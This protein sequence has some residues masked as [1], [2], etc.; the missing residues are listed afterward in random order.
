[1]SNYSSFSV[2][3]QGYSHIVKQ[4]PCEDNSLHFDGEG[5]HIGAVADGHGD[6]K[7]FRSSIGSSLAVKLAEKELLSLAKSRKTENRPGIDC[8]DENLMVKDVF[9]PVGRQI[10]KNIIGKWSDEVFKNYQDAPVSDEEIETAGIN[11]ISIY[12]IEDIRHIYGTTLVAFLLTDEYLLVLHQGDGRCVIVHQDGSIDQPVPWDIRCVGRET[13]SLCDVDAVNSF[14]YYVNDQKD[15]PIIACF[16]ASDG[17]ED[18]FD[19]QEEVNSFFGFLTAKCVELGSDGITDYLEKILP[20]YSKL[21]SRDDISI[22]GV[23]DKVAAQPYAE[24]YLL[25]SELHT[26]EA[27]ARIAKNK[28][29]SM[30]RKMGYLSNEFDKAKACYKATIEACE[31]ATWDRETITKRLRSR[32]MFKTKNKT[33]CKAEKAF[34][35]AKKEYDA[36]RERYNTFIQKLEEANDKIEETKESLALLEIQ[37]MSREDVAIVKNSTDERSN[38]M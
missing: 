17:V 38:F 9:D 34:L 10:I 18:S 16:V 4:T 36:Y 7:C 27:E 24:K 31:D 6:K 30:F 32:R 29:D 35:S 5:I 1:M 21:G 37:K 20:E 13:T 28:L 15:E 3:V 11:N 33:D 25:L 19:N 23:V 22:A 26:Y 8:Q 14:R 2:T 12:S